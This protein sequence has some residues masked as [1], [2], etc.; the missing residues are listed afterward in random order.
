MQHPSTGSL[1]E[2]GRGAAAGRKLAQPWHGNEPTG[3]GPDPAR[4]WGPLGHHH[5]L[6]ARAGGWQC[7]GFT[8]LPRPPSPLQGADGGTLLLPAS[9]ASGR[10]VLALTAS[11]G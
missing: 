11:V 1:K 10:M 9:S 6:A 3:A 7:W 4:L 8:L 5:P 2:A